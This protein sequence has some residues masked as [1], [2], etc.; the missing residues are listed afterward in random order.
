[1][2]WAFDRVLRVSRLLWNNR[3][4]ST[5]NEHSI[6]T[7]ELISQ[8]T[9]RLTLRRR[10][11]WTPGQHAYVILPSVSTLP[12]EAHP[13]TIA[14]IPKKLEGTD[15]K[16][17]VFLI[18]GRSGFTRRLKDHASRNGEGSNTVPALLDGPY[19]CPP[20]L[21]TFTTCVLI[22]GE[23]LIQLFLSHLISLT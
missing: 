21:N 5:N 20:N 19:G 23:W 9:V 1:M 7:V 15:D 13:F 14:S 8:D 10:F 16:E 3:I 12:T 6:A 2:I 4:W 22:A 11:T 18:R 17:V